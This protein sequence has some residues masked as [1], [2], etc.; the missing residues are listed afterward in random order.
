MLLPK[1]NHEEEAGNKAREGGKWAAFLFFNY[2]YCD[3]RLFLFIF[4]RLKL[5]EDDDEHEREP[6]FDELR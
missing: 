6:G 4:A 3:S 5:K 1:A 2:K